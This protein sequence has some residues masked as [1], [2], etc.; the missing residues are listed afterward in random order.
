MSSQTCQVRTGKVWSGQLRTGQVK[1]GQGQI[2]S[3]SWVCDQVHHWTDIKGVEKKT[4]TFENH[5]DE[6]V[7]PAKNM[8][9]GWFI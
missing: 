5:S 1:A 3:K 6:T 7:S 2:F 9:E 8:L 4:R